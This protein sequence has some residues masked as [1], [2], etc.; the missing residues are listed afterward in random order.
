MPIGVKC[1]IRNATTGKVERHI[2]M[3]RLSIYIQIG[4]KRFASHSWDVAFIQSLY[5]MFGNAATISIKHT[6][7]TSSNCSNF[8]N[9]SA[10]AGTTTYGIQVG[11]GVGAEDIADFQIGTLIAHGNG[12]GQVLY[13][14]VGGV[15]AGIVGTVVTGIVTRVLTGNAV[16][17]VSATEI[18][19]VGGDGA[20]FNCEARDLTGGVTIPTGAARTAKYS[21][22]TDEPFVLQFL[23]AFLIVMGVASPSGALYDVS[24]ADVKS[25]IAGNRLACNSPASQSNYGIVIGS[26]NAAFSASDYKLASQFL[27]GSGASQVLHGGCDVLTPATVGQSVYLTLTRLFWNISSSGAL[28]VEEVGLYAYVTTANKFLAFLRTLTGTI[29]WPFNTGKIVEYTIYTTNH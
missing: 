15:E 18:T 17:D 8:P 1:V 28:S 4:K 22:S 13:A 23:Q 11:T 16:G 25:Q 20:K 5:Y 27:V 3:G 10:A 7:G 9:L 2:E 14:A 29:A 12:A 21:I 19:L 26:G 24:H 6:D